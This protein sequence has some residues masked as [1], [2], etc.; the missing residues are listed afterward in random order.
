M[1]KSW[2]ET[3]VH[4]K[5]E[6]LS[7]L[8]VPAE[9]PIEKIVWPLS[10]LALR[11]SLQHLCISRNVPISHS[12]LIDG[13]TKNESSQISSSSDGNVVHRKVQVAHES[14]SNNN[15][16]NPS[17]NDDICLASTKIKIL[18]MKKKIKAKKRHE[19]ERMSQLTAKIANELGVKYIVDFG[20][21]LGHLA[22]F[23]AYA[24]GLN[25]CCLEKESA[26][27]DQAK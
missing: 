15:R 19:I 24:Y 21:G 5:P 27:T 1:P 25:V 3:L 23:L 6:H 4:V 7:D 14:D 9:R 17:K 12:T 18:L 22:R 10:L 8:L 11:K 20:S 2:M 16:N 26:L 13:H